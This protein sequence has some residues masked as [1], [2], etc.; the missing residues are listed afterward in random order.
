LELHKKAITRYETDKELTEAFG[1]LTLDLHK[2][3]WGLR[4]G[5]PLP[6][7]VVEA[8]QPLMPLEIPSQLA[9]AIPRGLGNKEILSAEPF[10]D[11]IECIA[12]E[13]GRRI[14]RIAVD[15][16]AAPP[17]AGSRSSETEPGALG[18]SCFKT[19]AKSDW[20][21]IREKCAG[22]LRSGG[23]TASLPHAKQDLDALQL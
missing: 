14:E 2:Y 10:R 23:S 15:A 9:A 4:V 5:K 11:A 20:A 8:G 18:L 13:K 1:A 3:R 22:H 21:D 6:I 7:C 17:E 16:P 19:P 12:H